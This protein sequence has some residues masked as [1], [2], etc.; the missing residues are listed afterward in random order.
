[1][2]G[3]IIYLPKYKDSVKYA[4]ELKDRLI[5]TGVDATLFEGT[6]GD[7][8]DEIFAKEN[9]TLQIIYYHDWKLDENEIRPGV[10]GCFHSHYRLWQKCVELDEPI[11]IFEDDLELKKPFLP[12]EWEDVLIMSF[13][14]DW[15]PYQEPLDDYKQYLDTDMSVPPKAIEYT[16]ICAPGLVAYGIKPK[17]AK[18]LVDEYKNGY[19]PADH[20]VLASLVK[21]Q[22][23][24][25]L[26]GQPHFETKESLTK[27][28]TEDWEKKNEGIVGNL[29]KKVGKLSK[30]F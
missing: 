27:K 19:A 7:E 14:G 17:A 25:H 1:M 6:Y 2:K 18:I 3:F 28:K 24:N 22:M 10:K 9:R 26:M 15:W 29:L 13:G 16:G 5:E 4:V 21:I 11:L 20:A 12:V 30:I 23:H 8:T